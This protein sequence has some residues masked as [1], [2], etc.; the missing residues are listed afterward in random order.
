MK[1]VSK[2]VPRRASNKV[3]S[4]EKKPAQET[5]PASL[6]ANSQEVAP[7]RLKKQPYSKEALQD[8]EFYGR[9]YSNLSN[10]MLIEMARL[11]GI[12][13]N[14]RGNGRLSLLQLL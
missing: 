9:K 5:A 6:N 13:S 1:A 2:I 12:S 4:L 3:N 8:V 14:T 7:S 11:R 10:E